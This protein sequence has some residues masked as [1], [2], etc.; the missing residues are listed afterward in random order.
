MSVLQQYQAYAGKTEDL[1]KIPLSNVAETKID[2]GKAKSNQTS[3][4][5]FQDK[6]WTNYMIARFEARFEDS[7]KPAHRRFFQYVKLMIKEGGPAASTSTKT[8]TDV[9]KKEP[10][11][12]TSHVMVKPVD[13]EEESDWER[14]TEIQ[15]NQLEALA[16]VI[17]HIPQLTTQGLLI[18]PKAKP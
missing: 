3:A 17:A 9:K 15:H 5:A 11:N 10:H 6:E 18:Q 12:Q 4:E 14:M 2:F 13:E 7:E 16:Q 1:E 8:K